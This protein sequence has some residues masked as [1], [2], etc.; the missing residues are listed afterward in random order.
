MRHSIGG[1]ERNIVADEKIIN[2][3]LNN[4]LITINLK[5]DEGTGL[6]K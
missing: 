6:L 2:A 1:Q 4:D 5:H 3:L